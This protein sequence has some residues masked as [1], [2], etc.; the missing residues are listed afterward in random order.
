MIGQN[1]ML[2]NNTLIDK[3][4]YEYI[5]EIKKKDC[6]IEYLKQEI[7]RLLEVKNNEIKLLKEQ[8]FQEIEN[9]NKNDSKLIN[10]DT[11]E[12]E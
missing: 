10:M 3:I 12:D 2:D 7:L 5:S 4:R 9:L 6:E 11:D 1:I 8:Y